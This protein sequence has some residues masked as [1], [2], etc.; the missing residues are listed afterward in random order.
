MGNARVNNTHGH[1]GS[2]LLR[3]FGDDLPLDVWLKTKMWPM[4]AKFTAETIEAAASL[5]ILEM[6]KSGTTTFLEMYH[7]HL[8]L[9]ANIVDQS[10]IRSVLTRGMIGLCSPLEQ[11]KKLAEAIE[12]N[13]VLRSIG[14]GRITTMLAPH[15]PYTCP[16]AFLEMVVQEAKKLSLPIHIHL[17]ETAQ[18]V[19]NHIDTYGKRPAIHLA[20]L[21][22]FEVPALIAHGV[23]LDAAELDI[24]SQ[25][26]V[27]VSHNP[28]SN[29]KLGSGIA[30]IPKMLERNIL[31]AIGTDSAASNNNLDMFQEMR[32]AALIHKGNQE[33]PTV[34]SA[35]DALL[36]ATYNGS[37]A[38]QLEE[39]G[40]LKIGK[41]ADF[42]VIDSQKPHLQ[43]NQQVISHLVYSASGSDVIDVYVRGNCIIRNKQ[44]LTLDEEKIIFEANRAFRNILS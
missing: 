40:I 39:T 2:S 44:C 1:I 12:L 14:E 28:I 25:Y 43:P 31:V 34:V 3:G 37:K 18:E 10:G 9:I 20:E 7:L 41:E 19:Q 17:S 35:Q 15:A 23:H 30:N 38:L 32:M 21:G 5:A 27:A 24:L 11:E 22:V 8:E 42:I 6:L 16:P 33:N 36:M 29:L 4:E 13:K 26:E